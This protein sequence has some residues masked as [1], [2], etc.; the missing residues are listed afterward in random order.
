VFLFYGFHCFFPLLCFTLVRLVS[1]YLFPHG[2][3][4]PQLTGRLAWSSGEPFHTPLLLVA[5]SGGA[6]GVSNLVAGMWHCVARGFLIAIFL[7]L[8]MML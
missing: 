5:L 2:I 4:F 7:L 6:C 1:G 3:V 8:L